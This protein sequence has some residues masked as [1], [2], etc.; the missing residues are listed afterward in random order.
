[1]SKA[2]TLIT[3]HLDTWTSAVK[4]KSSAGRGSGKK[5]ECYGIKKLRELILEL[6]VR[7]LL[8]PQ[9][10]KDE[11]TSELLKKVAKEKA[12]LIKE[13]KFKKQEQPPLKPAEWRYNL[14]IMWQWVRFGDIAL[15][16]AGKTLDSGRNSGDLRDYITTSN[17][18]WGYFDLTDVRQM[19][20]REEELEKC[21]ATKGDL[22]I[23]EGGEAGRASVWTESRDICFQN[24]I[25]R[26]RLFGGID[27]FYA[28]RFFE[29]LS[30]SGQIEKYRKGVGI[31]NM[32]G[33]ALASIVFPLPPLAEQQRIVAKVD[34][35]MALCD[36]LEQQQE[37]SVRTHASLV[38]T[39]LGAL[40]AASER[41]AFAEAWQRIASHFDTLFTTESSID[42]LKQ[43]ILQLAVMGKLVDEGSTWNESAL[44]DVAAEIVD[45]PHSTPKWTDEGEI[46]VRTNQFKAGCLDLSDSRFV[47]EETYKERIQR[48][49]PKSGDILYS[50]EGGIL[51]IACSVPPDTKLC[52]GQRMMLIRAGENLASEFLELVLNSPLITEIARRKTTG[53]AAPRVNVSTV[54][55]YPIPLPPLAEQ[56]RIVAKVDELVA[57][58]DLLKAR[59]QSAQATKVHIA[60][61]LVEA[62]IR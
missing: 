59:L 9:D 48:L 57:L 15:H 46:C 12:T 26:A 62:A 30:M 23:C 3:A 5:Q 13:G 41:G 6:A 33:K 53:G 22:L 42:Q 31:S 19:P 40:T 52:L 44:E 24:H 21:S 17:L 61:T 56:H 39:L 8:V 35:L 10:S 11:P 28:Y 20:I 1:M 29:H 34:E 36:Q 16:N 38:E 47:S 7:G 32:S 37:D 50:R 4:A 49:T 25:H 43:T 45:C 60:D 2:E 51:G 14:P 54:K 18:Y 27:P 58:C 55:A